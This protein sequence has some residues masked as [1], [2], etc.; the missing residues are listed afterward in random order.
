M[1][2]IQHVIV[3]YRHLVLDVDIVSTSAFFDIF[4]R[5]FFCEEPRQST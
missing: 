1:P 2:L 4:K 3:V 5:V